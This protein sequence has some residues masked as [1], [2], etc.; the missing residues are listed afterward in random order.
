[1]VTLVYRFGYEAVYPANF[2]FRGFCEV[3]PALEGILERSE[4]G[5][6][7]AARGRALGEDPAADPTAFPTRPPPGSKNDG[8]SP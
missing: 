6:E 4:R 8:D 5:D 1:M 2:A 3:R 7:G